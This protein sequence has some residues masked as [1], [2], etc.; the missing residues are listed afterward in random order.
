MAAVM[1]PDKQHT[2]ALQ[3]DFERLVGH[4][5]FSQT[6]SACRSSVATFDTLMTKKHTQNLQHNLSIAWKLRS[7]F[8]YLLSS[9]ANRRRIAPRSSS[10]RYVGQRAQSRIQSRHLLSA[11]LLGHMAGITLIDVSSVLG[12]TTAIPITIAVI[13]IVTLMQRTRWRGFRALSR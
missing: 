10:R 4:L 5:A 12:R 6:A 2:Y 13:P 9:I 11:S 1:K 3:H 7:H 8:N